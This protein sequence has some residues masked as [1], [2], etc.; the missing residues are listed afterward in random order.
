ML[1][2]L[3]FLKRNASA[4]LFILLYGL[5]F[6]LLV[7]ERSIPGGKW[8][9]FRLEA[10]S[11]LGNSFRTVDGYFGLKAENRS[12]HRENLRLHHMLENRAPLHVAV[13]PGFEYVPARVV[14]RRIRSGFDYLIIDKGSNAGLAPQNGVFGPE[15]VAGIVAAASPHFAK[16]ITLYHPDVSVDVQLQKSGIQGFTQ[17]KAEFFPYILITDLPYE[18]NVVPGDTIVTSGSSYIFPPGIPV[19]TVHGIRTDSIHKSRYITAVPV[20]DY[21]RIRHV[22]VS[23]NRYKK[24]LDSLQHE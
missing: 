4:G 10:G 2:F 11:W 9:R 14:N 5:A 8:T 19:A 22:Y 12:L 16:V 20:T 23:R 15:G 7:S 3:Y 18:T 1:N 24:E 21:R 13:P 6:L 17:A